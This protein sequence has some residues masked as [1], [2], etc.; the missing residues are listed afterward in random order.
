MVYLCL[1][2]FVIQFNNLYQKTNVNIEVI[3]RETLELNSPIPL[4][5]EAKLISNEDE[6]LYYSARSDKP[7]LKGKDWRGNNIE[8][9]SF[10]SSSTS[11]D[12]IEGGLLFRTYG[13][14]TYGNCVYISNK[15]N[16]MKVR[17]MNELTIT[18][19]EPNIPKLKWEIKKDSTKTIGKHLCIKADTEFRGRKY[20]VWFTP[21]IPINKGPW[22]LNGLP[23]LILQATDK[24]GKIKF[25]FI[26]LKPITEKIIFSTEIENWTGKQCSYEESKTLGMEWSIK[27]WIKRS[28]LSFVKGSVQRL[29]V[30]PDDFL[31]RY[32]KEQN[33]ILKKYQKYLTVK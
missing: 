18:Y 1:F 7:G 14:D 9:N 2:S 20:E 29:N 8:G 15:S 17:A 30:N 4:D 33:A 13:V 12:H 11:K 24:E 25:D 31:E 6:S 22:K 16:T 23:G 5:R 3:Y 28:N 32:P 10:T 27:D 21:E 26:K 19:T